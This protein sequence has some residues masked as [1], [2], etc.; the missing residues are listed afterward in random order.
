MRRDRLI[1]TQY[2][3]VAVGLLTC[4]AV[5]PARALGPALATFIATLAVGVRRH[6]LG[7][8]P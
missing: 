5:G 2:G 8:L 3:I 6:G 4:T 7:R 1:L